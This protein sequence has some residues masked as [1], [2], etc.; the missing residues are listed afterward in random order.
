MVVA[1]VTTIARLATLLKERKIIIT[2]LLITVL[3]IKRDD[4]MVRPRL[5]FALFK[6][7][8]ST[9]GWILSGVNTKV[10]IEACRFWIPGYLHCPPPPIRGWLLRPCRRSGICRWATE[11]LITR[12][13]PK[14]CVAWSCLFK[15]TRVPL[16]Q[17]PSLIFKPQKGPAFFKQT[18]RLFYWCH[19]FFCGGVWPFLVDRNIVNTVGE[20]RALKSAA[21]LQRFRCVWATRFP[22]KK[23]SNFMLV[24][25]AQRRIASN[26][27]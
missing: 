4:N 21:V 5:A 3:I 16:C 25:L 20:K 9:I 2:L 7:N 13:L 8:V 1:Y 19:A 14:V 22:F 23:S 17:C 24:G 11:P 26:V 27:G 15:V 6:R 10:P 12:N 18:S